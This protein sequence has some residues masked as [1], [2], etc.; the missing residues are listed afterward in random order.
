MRN[1]FHLR[2]AILQLLRKGDWRSAHRGSGS[3]RPAGFRWTRSTAHSASGDALAGE[4]NSALC[5]SR[6]DIHSGTNA[7]LSDGLGVWPAV[8]GLAVQLSAV[9]SLFDRWIAGGLWRRAF[10]LG[11]GTLSARALG[12]D[13]PL[14]PGIPGPAAAPIWHGIGHLHHLGAAAGPFRPGVPAAVAGLLSKEVSFISF[15]FK[16][17]DGASSSARY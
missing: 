4:R 14:G 5:E 11:L 10:G 13:A 7:A 17:A 16:P 2:R 15:A 9:R 6:V 8:R 12:A 3:R 1:A